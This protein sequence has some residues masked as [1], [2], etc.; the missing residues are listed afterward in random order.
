[1]GPKSCIPQFVKY[2]VLQPIIGQ[3]KSLEQTRISTEK[4]T[5]MKQDTPYPYPMDDDE[6][7][8]KL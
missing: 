6:D 5:G 3:V 4:M 8:E 7:I 2:I 1:M